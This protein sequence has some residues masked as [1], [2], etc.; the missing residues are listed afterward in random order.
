MYASALFCLQPIFNPEFAVNEQK[1]RHNPVQTL[2][3]LGFK[4]NI[5]Q[6]TLE[7]QKS[8]FKDLAVLIKRLEDKIY[9]VSEKSIAI[10]N[11]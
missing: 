11:G 6:N 8:E 5:E 7:L 3:W 2:D 9:S 1:S 10:I 4:W